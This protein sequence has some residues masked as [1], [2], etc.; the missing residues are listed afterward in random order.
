M[1]GELLTARV[2]TFI[3][4]LLLLSVTLALCLVVW[5]AAHGNNPLEEAFVKRLSALSVELDT[6]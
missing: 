2:N 4:T 5:Q 1:K 6:L 3:G